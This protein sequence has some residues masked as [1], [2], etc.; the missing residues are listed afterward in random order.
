MT[1]DVN[2]APYVGAWIE[3]SNLG[4]NSLVAKVAPYVGAWIETYASSILS[5][6]IMSHP[7]WVRGLKPIAMYGGVGA[8][9]VAPYVGAWIETWCCRNS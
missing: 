7:T 2:V 5:L 1:N 6:H 8:P 4:L 9:T 3:T